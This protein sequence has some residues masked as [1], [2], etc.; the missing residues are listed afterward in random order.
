MAYTPTTWTTGD[1]ITATAMNKIENGI[2]GAGSALICNAS[3][4]DSAENFVLDKTVQEIHEALMSGTP[5]YCKYEYGVIGSDYISHS[6]LAPITYIYTYD[7]A[8]VIRIVV[9]RATLGGATASGSVSTYY[10][11][12]P[13]VVIFEAFSLNSYPVFYRTASPSAS[14]TFS[15]SSFF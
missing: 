1:T 12:V 2:A 13:S 9:Q 6:W 15:T 14:A 11:L 7:T 10:C 8:N 3:Y 5:V 4:S